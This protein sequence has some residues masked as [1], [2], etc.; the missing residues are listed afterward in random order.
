VEAVAPEPE[1]EPEPEPHEPI[2]REPAPEAPEPQPFRGDWSTAPLG[3]LGLV[4]LVQR[5]GAS[6][7]RRREWVATMATLAPAPLLAPASGFEPAPAAEAAQAMAA[8]FGQPACD[9][10]AAADADDANDTVSEPQPASLAPKELG[11]RPNFLGAWPMAAD[12]D[13]DES[14]AIPSFT[15]PLHRAVAPTIAFD[16]EPGAAGNDDDLGDAGTDG[17][18]HSYSSLLTMRNP[19]NPKANGFVRI[20]EPEADHAVEPVVVF[21]GH[22]QAAP[23]TLAEPRAFDPPA[24]SEAT[25]T[26]APQPAPD[27]DAALRAALATL[28]RMSGTA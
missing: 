15:L 8:Y 27:A 11:S 17:P 10:P 23:T 2:L 28:Q 5:L 19:F 12:E 1:L 24:G 22:D 14:D 3:E 26:G 4:Q 21:P 6:L 25:A 7:E 18:D 16:D 9:A 13:E 20:E